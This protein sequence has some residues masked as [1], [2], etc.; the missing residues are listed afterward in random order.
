MLFQFVMER[1]LR[2]ESRGLLPVYNV[3]K[4]LP[5]CVALI[6]IYFKNRCEVFEICI[7]I[8]HPL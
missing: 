4:Q 1:L 7:H 5:D 8:L 6:V 2:K 3:F